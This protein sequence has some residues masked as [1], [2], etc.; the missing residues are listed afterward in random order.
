MGARSLLLTHTLG[1]RK[2]DGRSAAWGLLPAALL[3][4]LTALPAGAADYLVAPDGSDETGDGSLQRPFATIAKGLSLAQPG[5]RVV[6][7]GGEYRLPGGEGTV[8]FPRAGAP[9]RPI[10]LTAHE[11]EYVAVL[12]SVR[13]THWQ[14]HAAGIYKCRAPEK[15]IRGLYE[16]GER[17]VHPRE[18][19]KR[20]DPPVSAI[21]GPGRWTQQDG[22]VYLWARDGAN[23]ADHR[24]EAS[25]IVVVAADKPWVRV[26][27][28]HILFGQPIGLNLRADHVVAENVEVAHVSNSVDNAYGA[29]ISHC[30]FSTLRDSRIHDSYYWGDHGSNSHV[31]SSIDC[32]DAGPNFVEGCEIFNGGLGVGTKGA[33]RELVVLANRIYDVLNGVVISGER[34]SGP[35]AGK[36]DR[37]HYLVYGNRITDCRNGVR[38]P[39]GHTSGNRVYNNLFERCGTAIYGRIVKAAPKETAFANNL[40]LNNA[41]AIG[42]VGGRK[43]D[44]TLPLFHEAGL[45][46][47]RNLYWGNDIHWRHPLDWSRELD[48]SLA[49]VQSY[50]GYGWETGSVRADPLLDERGRPARNSPAVGGGLPLALPDY[51]DKPDAWHIGLAPREQNE[52]EPGLT[53]SIA[54]SDTTAAPGETI[55]LRARLTNDWKQKDVSLSGAAIV[56][57]HFRYANVWHYDKQELHR[58][59]VQLPRRKLAPG[60]SL[61]LTR[62][63]GWKDP[64]NGAM[65]E[66]F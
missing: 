48:M 43:G 5:D 51:V 64:V 49:E 10:T 41:I 14:P 66:T 9:G 18:R 27:K 36:H 50:R 52:P 61:D 58:T 62:L 23:P 57:F 24:I 55:R 12:G 53:L 26:E 30:S 54:G 33:V 39:G 19:A 28:L 37:G 20:V 17:L 63:P 6:L 45:R 4:W 38:F 1:H 31:V 13:L 11:S 35:G 65:G 44:E 42:L 29:Y 32:G 25:Q 2:A 47:Q 56:T 21:A 15:H 46:S 3:L 16:D 8:R 40:L 22:W 59:T 7:R 60:E 34:S